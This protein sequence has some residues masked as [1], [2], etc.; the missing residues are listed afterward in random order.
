[1]ENGDSPEENGDSPEVNVTS[2]ARL[3]SS[4]QEVAATF[5]APIVR[6]SFAEFRSLDGIKFGDS[7]TG[8]AILNFTATSVYR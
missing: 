2:I 1:M 8:V 6:V 7:V 5:V 3:L 4:R